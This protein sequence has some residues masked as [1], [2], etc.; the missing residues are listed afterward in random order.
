MHTRKMGNGHKR[1]FNPLTLGVAGSSQEDD[2]VGG[3]ED[4]SLGWHQEAILTAIR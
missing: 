3:E 1:A 2:A 4:V